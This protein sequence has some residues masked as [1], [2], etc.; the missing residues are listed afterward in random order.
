TQSNAIL[1][2]EGKPQRPEDS[3]DSLRKKYPELSPFNS[4]FNAPVCNVWR[5]DNPDSGT[6]DPV[7]SDL[8]VLIL[9]GAYDPVCPP[10]F[11]ELTAK[12][13]P[14][15]TFLVIPAASHAAI[16]TNDCVRSYASDLLLKKNKKE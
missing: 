5:P 15:S 9:A 2:Y 14:N 11:G 1:C 6:F 3:E 13:L 10:F 4:G 7:V 16:H 12:T 8:P